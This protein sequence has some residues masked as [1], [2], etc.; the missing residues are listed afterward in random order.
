MTNEIWRD[1]VGYEGLY[2]IS[3]CGRLRSM[4]KR[5][6]NEEIICKPFY[7]DGYARYTLRKDGGKKHFLAH[8]LVAK[9]F[10]P[11]PRGCKYVDHIDT[12]K[13]NNCI[14]AIENGVS[15]VHILDGRIAHCLLLEI[16][17]HS[18]IGT[19]I[20]EDEGENNDK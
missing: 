15:R 2:Q 10:I 3:S 4:Q 1:V 14:D 11:N 19:A 8:Q 7:Q 18:G 5:G 17:T 16:F 9:M 13:L 12:N 20:I 6:S